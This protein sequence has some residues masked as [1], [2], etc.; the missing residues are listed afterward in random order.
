MQESDL[1]K[2]V[3]KRLKEVL[4]SLL[5]TSAFT[6]RKVT[7]T[8]T[9]GLQVINRDYAN[10]YASVASLPKGSVAGQTV[11]ATDLNYLVTKDTNYNWRNGAG[12]VVARG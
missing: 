2:L 9:D 10:K 3:D 4:P 8:P 6:D 7:D 12:S 5:R 1:E 11:F